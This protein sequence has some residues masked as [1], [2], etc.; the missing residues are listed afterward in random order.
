MGNILLLRRISQDISSPRSRLGLEKL[1]LKDWQY[2]DEIKNEIFKHV[3][4]SLN[5]VLKV[6]EPQAS[7]KRLS[8]F[9]A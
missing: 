4:R 8:F 7:P 9:L 3:T 2:T 1:F 6:G 5:L